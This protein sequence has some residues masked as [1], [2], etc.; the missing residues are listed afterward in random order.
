MN[1]TNKLTSPGTYLPGLPLVVPCQGT[2]LDRAFR[3]LPLV[4]AALRSVSMSSNASAS[5]TLTT[6]T[7][8]LH[9]TL[10]VLRSY[11]PCTH[12]HNRAQFLTLVGPERRSYR[13]P[14]CP[15]FE[16][17]NDLDG[18]NGPPPTLGFGF[19]GVGLISRRWPAALAHQCHVLPWLLP[20]AMP[21]AN[22][23]LSGPR[24]CSPSLALCFLPPPAPFGDPVVR[25]S[26]CDT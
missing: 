21:S 10:I 19:G 4:A 3:S 20:P 26:L 9:I 2:S 23:S 24:P 15:G 25:S 13:C 17:W 11:P 6:C 7:T 5:S 16:Q 18:A 1:W 8:V 22:H 12:F 14:T